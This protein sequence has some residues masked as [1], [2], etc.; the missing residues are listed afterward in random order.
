MSFLVHPLKKKRIVCLHLGIWCLFFFFSN[1]AMMFTVTTNLYGCD[2]VLMTVSKSHEKAQ[3]EQITYV[4]D[5]SIRHNTNKHKLTNKSEFMILS[6]S[7]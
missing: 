7:R 1:L 6:C 5:N 3:K 2:P 4:N